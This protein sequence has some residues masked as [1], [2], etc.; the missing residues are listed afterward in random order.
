MKKINKNLFIISLATLVLTACSGNIP[1]A[2]G[3]SCDPATLSVTGTGQVF[4]IPDIAHISV[5]VRTQGA[6][7]SEA[8]GLN[9]TQA[10]QIKNTL[11]AEGVAERIFRHPTST[12]TSSTIMTFRANRPNRITVLKIRYT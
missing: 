12:Y 8:I 11:L 1:A 9:N 2:V 3:D 6:T 10:Q 7:V 4:V 5:G